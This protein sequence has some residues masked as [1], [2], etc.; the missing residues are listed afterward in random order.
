MYFEWKLRRILLSKKRLRIKAGFTQQLS[1][2]KKKSEGRAIK[3]E[4]RPVQEKFGPKVTG[5]LAGVK[6]CVYPS[7]TINKS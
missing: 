7:N 5:E 2:A 6:L 3:K 1:F 4:F